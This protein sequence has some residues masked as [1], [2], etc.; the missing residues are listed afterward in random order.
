MTITSEDTSTCTSSGHAFIDMGGLW[1]TL[2]HVCPCGADGCPYGL[3]PA[4]TLLEQLEGYAPD[5]SE[6]GLP[7][8]VMTFTGSCD[9]A[10]DG[11]FDLQLIELLASA[12]RTGMVTVDA[13]EGGYRCVAV[14]PPIRGGH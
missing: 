8:F 4:L 1:A 11:A 7:S 6:G 13:A 2:S 14:L 3:V 12:Q 9:S 10:D 5:S